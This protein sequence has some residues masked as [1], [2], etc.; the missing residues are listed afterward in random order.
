MQTSTTNAE[1]NDTNDSDYSDTEVPIKTSIYTKNLRI[2]DGTINIKVISKPT[3]EDDDCS[4]TSSQF[5]YP[6]IGNYQV[7][8]QQVKGRFNPLNYQIPHHL[9]RVAFLR[10]DRFC[11]KKYNSHPIFPVPTA[12]RFIEKKRNYEIKIL[13]SNVIKKRS[14]R[15]SPGNGCLLLPNV[16]YHRD[17]YWNQIFINAEYANEDEYTDLLSA[18]FQNLLKF[19]QDTNDE[20]YLNAELTFE[21]PATE[22]LSVYSRGTSTPS[23]SFDHSKYTVPDYLCDGEYH[24]RKTNRLPIVP[25]PARPRYAAISNVDISDQETLD[26]YWDASSDDES[27]RSEEPSYKRKYQHTESYAVLRAKHKFN[28]YIKTPGDYTNVHWPRF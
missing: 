4:T 8:S 27:W 10:E 24:Q 7:V 3:L 25:I 23:S 13:S 19:N 14:N 9:G 2:T 18:L 5:S 28:K 20:L 11:P 15:Y 26:G 6:F 21:L 16:Y 22:D 1:Y 17:R 12:V